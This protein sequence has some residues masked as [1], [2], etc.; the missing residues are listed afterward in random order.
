MQTRIL[1]TSAITFIL[2]TALSSG[3]HG[4]T[5]R[6]MPWE[7]QAGIGSANYFGDIGGSAAEN[8]WYGLRDINIIR[9][10]LTGT[11]GARYNHN[12]YLSFSGHLSLGWLSGD[13]AGGPNDGR[14]Y[15]FNTLFMEPMGRVEFFPLRD[16]QIGEGLDRRGM[17]RN[18]ATFSTYIWTGFGTIVYGVIPND[19]LKARRERDNIEHGFITG[20]L[21]F[22]VGAKIGIMNV[23]DL[24]IEL[25]GRWSFNDYLDGFTSP[26]ATS[27]D[28]YY[29]T[30]INIV[31]RLKSLEEIGLNR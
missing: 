31:Y 29:L 1:L 13:D 4:Q 25:G 26:T 10:R 28:I 27:N 2:L 5:W 14:G 15:V 19:A 24:G 17:V 23:I 7:F 16:L 8:N 20:V 11:A 22:G 21:P 18:Y 9:S 6:T 12:Q 30:T 3:L